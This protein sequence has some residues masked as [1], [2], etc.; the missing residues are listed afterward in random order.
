MYMYTSISKLVWGIGDLY[1]LNGCTFDDVK[2][3]SHGQNQTSYPLLK[4]FDILPRIR[5][6]FF[7]LCLSGTLSRGVYLAH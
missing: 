5:L 6:A 2:F 3:E 7:Y 4:V 1:S